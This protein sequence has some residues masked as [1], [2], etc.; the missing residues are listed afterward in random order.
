VPDGTPSAKVLLTNLYN[1]SQPLIRYE[2]T[3]QFTRHPADPGSGYLR[4]TVEGR[5][6]ETACCTT[7]RTSSPAASTP[8]NVGHSQDGAFPES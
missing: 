1:H 7:S 8:R 4:A 3:D 2:L 5:A 6:D